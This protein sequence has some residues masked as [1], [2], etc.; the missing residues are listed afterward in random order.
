MCVGEQRRLLVPPEVTYGEWKNK[1]LYIDL[2]LLS[3]D[4]KGFKG[5]SGASCPCEGLCDSLCSRLVVRVRLRLHSHTNTS[6]GAWCF[7]EC[8]R[9]RGRGALRHHYYLLQN[10]RPVQVPFTDRSAGEEGRL[11]AALCV[12]VCVCVCLCFVVGGERREGQEME[13]GAERKRERERE[14][15]PALHLT[16]SLSPLLLV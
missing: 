9:V 11:Y 14:T 15:A 2:E 16:Y 12:C 6:F 13:R 8:Y 10:L 1:A 5:A 7:L 4:D 3:V